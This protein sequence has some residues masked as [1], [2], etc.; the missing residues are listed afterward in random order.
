MAS[1]ALDP[2]PQA[3]ASAPSTHGTRWPPPGEPV[4][5]KPGT[6]GT[7]TASTRGS[8]PAPSAG[9]QPGLVC[10]TP[11]LAAHAGGDGAFGPSDIRGR[12]QGAS[13]ASAAGTSGAFPGPAS[14]GRY[15]SRER[16]L[17][18]ITSCLERMAGVNTERLSDFHAPGP[19]ESST[20]HPAPPAV[21]VAPAA[22]LQALRPGDSVF[23]GPREAP[24]SVADYLDRLYTYFQCNPAALFAALCYIRRASLS[25]PYLQVTPLTVHRQAR[26]WELQ[27]RLGWARVPCQESWPALGSRLR[28]P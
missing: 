19:T 4:A 7:E 11:S 15:F 6:S 21:P 12:Q 3:S 24:L 23:H 17:P 18:L 9:C 2:G 25:D 28:L 8:S 14:R 22:A 26:S 16:W 20:A 13:D 27:S 1:P 5:G 10:S